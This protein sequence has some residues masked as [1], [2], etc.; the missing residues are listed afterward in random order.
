MKTRNLFFI[1]L[2]VVI[3][4]F[5]NVFA[6][7]V[8]I[9][10][11]KQVAF[12]FYVEHSM[13]PISAKSLSITENFSISENTNILYYV[14]NFS[15]D[16]FAI[17]AADDVIQPVLGYSYEG[18]YN[19]HNQSPEFIYWTGTYK[20]QIIYAITSNILPT[21][22]I[23]AAW[24]H[25]NVTPDKFSP[26]KEIMAVSPLLTSTWNQD[27]CYNDLCPA[28]ASSTA[29]GHA[30]AGCVA[31]AMG[32]VMN[33]Y[34]YPTTGQSSHG[35]NS[36]NY[37]YLS[38]NF[39]ATTYNWSGMANSCTASNNYI[40]TLLYHCGVSVNM[41]YGPTGSS[42][43]SGDVP[44]ALVTY[45]K[46]SS[47]ITY[48]TKS[49]YSDVN[50]E[51]IL[52]TELDNKRPM[53]YRGVSTT[54][55]GHAWVCDGYQGTNYFHM[56]WGWSGT[57][58]GY[59]YLNSLV[60]GSGYDLTQQQEAICNIYPGS[61]YPTNCSGQ[62]TVTPEIGNIEDGSG[63]SNYQNNLDCSWLISPTVLIDHLR[64]TFESLN[65]EATNDKVIIY[66]CPNTSSPVLGTYSGTSL[67]S[68][69]TSTSPSVLVRFTT[70]GSVTSSGWRLNY[71]SVYPVFCS[72]LV[73]L[74]N[75]SGT[76]SDGSGSSNYNN[77]SNC[78]W[79]IQPPNAVSI[80][81]HFLNFNT[82]L[83]N[84]KVIISD[85][86]HSTT[87]GTFSGTSLPADV[88]SPSG[89]MLV[90]FTTNTSITSTGWSA[91]YNSI[92]S[93]VEDYS[94]VKGLSVF[95]NPANNHLYV[96]FRVTDGKN[97]KLQMFN[98]TGQE[99]YTDE[100]SGSMDKYSKDIDVSQL[101]KGIYNLRIIAS[102]E[103][104]NKKVVVE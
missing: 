19:D 72:G 75:A 39:G 82:E 79:Q 30:W 51:N 32:Q 15:N 87:L 100:L 68:L 99:V 66:D 25:L 65:T 102:G 78:R 90:R 59:F 98:I 36:P 63:P 74:T 35:Y 69:I 10:M 101:S 103:K 62:V 97:V 16:G 3:F 2:V 31:V 55:G 80:T 84:D 52:K 33:Y 22:E 5:N 37:G 34:R 47:S 81:L 18:K 58:N 48:K 4:C 54:L 43:L 28:D 76:I 40:A 85:P 45:F 95:P 94:I 21:A 9:I 11:A 29:E 88:T 56:N 91:S 70:N 44:S 23:D 12:N 27:A 71:T 77:S 50:W 8:D 61:G 46:Y 104:V 7:K 14:F 1:C 86:V 67:P 20:Q 41:N 93:G 42:A 53:I 83:T 24:A 17:V 96:S 38:A 13:V 49:S 73:T 64:I 57:Y 60:P 92:I 89:Q 26:M 6:K